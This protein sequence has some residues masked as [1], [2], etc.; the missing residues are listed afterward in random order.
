[1]ARR[2]I[3]RALIE[4][5]PEASRMEAEHV[6][7]LLEGLG[8]SSFARDLPWGLRAFGEY[9]TMVISRTDARTSTVAPSL[10]SVPGI[11]ALGEAGTISAEI[12]DP[13]DITGSASSIVFDAG[14]VSGE[15]T[16][17]GPRPGDRMRPLGMQGT[18]KVSDLLVDAKVP[19]RARAAV[20][21]VR[22][23]ERIVWL[24]GVR[25]SDEFRV[26]PETEKAVRLEWQSSQGE[27]T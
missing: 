11:T 4:T 18:R 3:R 23:G 15:L 19:K 1:M 20:P 10:L 17:D 6:E 21:V 22:D 2:T 12:A 5:F 16:V 9:D 27:S 7:V 8:D 25:M 24:A 14:R 13:T 26:T